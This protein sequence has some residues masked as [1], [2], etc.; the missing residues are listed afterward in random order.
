MERSM[1]RSV[2]DHSFMSLMPTHVY[3]SGWFGNS[4]TQCEA[5]IPEEPHS[6]WS[7]AQRFPFCLS[8]RDPSELSFLP[9]LQGALR[10][11]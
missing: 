5:Y 2:F 10:R 4:G 9:L 8:Q 3:R 6:R 1:P 11:R 7:S